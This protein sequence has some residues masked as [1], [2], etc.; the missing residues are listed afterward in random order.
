M[1]LLVLFS[2][3]SLFCNQVLAQEDVMEEPMVEPQEE[4]YQGQEDLEAEKNYVTEEEVVEEPAQEI[5]D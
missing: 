3:L 5:V 2:L 4:S 1:K